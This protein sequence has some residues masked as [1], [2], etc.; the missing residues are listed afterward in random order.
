MIFTNSCDGIVSID[1]LHKEN[2]MSIFPNPTTN[3]LTIKY[4]DLNNS[5]LIIYNLM[6]SVLLRKNSWSGASEIKLDVSS[7]QNGIYFLEIKTKSGA[8]VQ[9]FVVNR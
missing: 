9:K 1:E 6:G 5:E 7:L 2:D 3:E 4:A 8:A